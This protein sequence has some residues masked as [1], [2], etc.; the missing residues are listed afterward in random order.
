VGRGIPKLVAGLALALGGALGCGGGERQVACAA[1]Q[2]DCG[3]VCRDL[4]ADPAHCGACGLRCAT[5]G[6]CTAGACGC[7]SPTELCGAACVDTSTSAAHCGSCTHACGAGTCSGGACT[8]ANAAGVKDCGVATSPQCRG[9]LADRSNCGDCNVVCLSGEICASGACQACAAPS[10]DRCGN[11]CVA[12]A[13]DLANCGACGTACGAGQSCNLG[14]CVCPAGQDPCGAACVDL[15]TD[16]A[17][18]GACG[19]ACPAGQACSSGTCAC[20][21]GLTCGALCCEGTACCGAG[22]TSCQT[23]HDSGTP[24]AGA[25]FFDCNPPGSKEAAQN[26]ALA[27]APAGHASTTQGGSSCSFATEC[28]AWENAP[29]PSACGVWCYD[30]MWRGMVAIT[31]ISP[32]CLCPDPM[33]PSWH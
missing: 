23:K 3:G 13:T 5:G 2:T 27:W 1:G 12:L 11:A 14:Q 18:C 21:T 19:R 6:T 31:T 7:P 8:C 30:G 16:A 10:P 28:V 4:A 26:A 9:T 17:N 32:V 15:Q 29:T 24:P 25:V 33:S 22:G 20:T